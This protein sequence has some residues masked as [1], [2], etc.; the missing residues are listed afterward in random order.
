CCLQ[1]RFAP[2]HP[3]SSARMTWRGQPFG[4]RSR[5]FANI[6][7]PAT[8]HPV[9]SMRSRG[10]ALCRRPVEPE[11]EAIIEEGWMIDAI[12]IADKRVGEAAEVHRCGGATPAIRGPMIGCLA[13]VSPRRMSP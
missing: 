11:Q 6:S 2:A 8:G 9:F 3:M 12:C 1:G 13:L 10:T 7:R 5:E 4:R